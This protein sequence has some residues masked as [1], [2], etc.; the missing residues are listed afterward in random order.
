MI[1]YILNEQ[2]KN[3]VEEE[4]KS[5]QDAELVDALNYMSLNDIVGDLILD[6]D[7]KLDQLDKERK[8]ELIFLE[9]RLSQLKSEQNQLDQNLSSF[10]NVSSDYKSFSESHIKTFIE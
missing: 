7:Q 9:K 8:S 5:P 4:Q 2:L 3:I 10:Q 1:Q 6:F